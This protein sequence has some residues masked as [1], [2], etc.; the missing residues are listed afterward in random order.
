[1]S[2]GTRN[3]IA[4]VTVATVMI[5][6]AQIFQTGKPAGLYSVVIGAFIGGALIIIPVNYTTSQRANTE[7][8]L[9]NERLG[10]TFI[11]IGCIIWGMAECLWSYYYMQGLNPFP[12]LADIGFSCFPLLVFIGL[13]LQPSSGI[14]SSR[15]LML[16]D[17]L[18]SMGALLA[19]GWFLLLGTLAQ[20]PYLTGL[21][22][23]LSLW[24]PTS[25]IA[26]LSCVIFLLI[27]NQ[28][29]VYQATARRV[30]LIVLGIGLGIFAVSDFNFNLMASAG[31][32]TGQAWI[33]TGWPSGIMLMGVAAYLRSFLPST[34]S[35]AIKQHIHR[36]TQRS[37]FG[38][39]QSIPY[40]LLTILFAMLVFNILS[41]DPNQRNIRPVLVFATVIVVVLVIIR[42][43]LTQLDNERLTR[44]Q[45][46]VLD[47][48]ATAN[49]QIEEQAQ[50]IAERNTILEEDVAYL[51]EVHAKLANGNLRAR[52][53]LTRFTSSDLMPLAQS[54]NLMADRLIHFE[55]NEQRLHNLSI[56]LGEAI[57]ALEKYR[58]GKP[59]VV[60]PSCANSP[61]I[62]RL[63]LAAG[64]QQA[65]ANPQNIPQP[66]GNEKPSMNP[67]SPQP[68]AT[69]PMDTPLPISPYPVHPNSPSFPTKSRLINL[70]Q[71]TVTP[72]DERRLI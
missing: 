31:A 9:G 59:L 29:P 67:I 10:W 49:N 41:N 23:F 47:R 57:S 53:R 5:A 3:V 39:V 25:D 68:L 44:Q 54:F 69:R 42:Q 58:M 61:E 21:G 37:S 38:P 55:H 65:L 70:D 24:Y 40:I 11:G 30:S 62:Y 48:L 18:I 33:V 35:E 8:W 34:S 50:K 46:I 36:Q 45:A 15:L 7:S 72:T 27:R 26:L 1:M 2:R 32:Y 16:L 14:Q 51:K 20:T 12:S 6:L 56:A 43:I 4:S 22:K 64:F 28:G 60:P 63:L 71:N 52:A 66:A 13:I 17:S 19:I